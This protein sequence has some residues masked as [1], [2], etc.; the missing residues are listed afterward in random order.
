MA[1]CKEPAR[2][3]NFI[4]VIPLSRKNHHQV[5]LGL[6]KCYTRLKH[7]G[8]E[9]TRFHS[10][11]GKEFMGEAVTRWILARDMMKTTNERG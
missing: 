8:F 7:L 3:R 2:I 10:D 1:K 5:L 4:Q 6:Q 11:R 9:P